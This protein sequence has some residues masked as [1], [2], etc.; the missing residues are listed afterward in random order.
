MHARVGKQGGSASV[1][2]GT[3]RGTIQGF[4]RRVVEGHLRP[5]PPAVTCD[6][7]RG[8]PLFRTGI[9]SLAL[10]SLEGRGSRHGCACQ[11]EMSILPPEFVPG[12]LWQ[13]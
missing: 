5:A 1:L 4:G 7:C 6:P 11:T 13:V 12:V 8:K 2:P 3:G 10:F 9:Q